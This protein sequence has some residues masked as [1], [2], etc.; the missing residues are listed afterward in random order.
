MLMKNTF[1]DLL[2]ATHN[3]GEATEPEGV[4]VDMGMRAAIEYLY[5]APEFKR[6]FDV[7]L[8][9]HAKAM[10][11]SDPEEY[12]FESILKGFEE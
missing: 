1:E 4:L 3:F 12:A 11:Q 8:K 6:G 5:A 9:E 2:Y 10:E 7:A